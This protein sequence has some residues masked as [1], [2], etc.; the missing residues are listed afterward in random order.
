MKFVLMPGIINNRS[1]FVV[2]QNF[3]WKTA[4]LIVMYN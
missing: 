1:N 2:L 4:S 3:L